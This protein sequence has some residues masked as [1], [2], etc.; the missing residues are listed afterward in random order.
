MK[1]KNKKVGNYAIKMDTCL[2]RGGFA[3]TYMAFK[4]K[5]Y[6]EPYACKVIQKKDIQKLLQNDLN[7][8]IKRVQEEYKALQNLKHPNIVQFMDVEETTNN[9]YLFFEYCEQDL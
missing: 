4:D 5:N 1:E 2:G 3:T 6:Q 7:Y 9:L 8:F